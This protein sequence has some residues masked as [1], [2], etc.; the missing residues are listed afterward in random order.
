MWELTLARY[1]ERNLEE[2]RKLARKKRVS[3]ELLSVD[4]MLRA[5]LDLAETAGTKLAAI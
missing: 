2:A 1:A 5:A 4:Y 3:F